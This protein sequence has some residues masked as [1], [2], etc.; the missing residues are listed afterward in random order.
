MAERAGDLL[1]SV[2]WL[3]QAKDRSVDQC[4]D[5]WDVRQRC[6]SKPRCGFVANRSV[7]QRRGREHGERDWRRRCRLA[8][9]N[10]LA[11]EPFDVVPCVELVTDAAEHAD[12]FE[13]HT[14]VK[15]L[16]RYVRQRDP[17]IRVL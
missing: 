5:R 15:A 1:A 7:E 10:E 2:Q 13:P 14:P 11:L 9:R 6:P 4:A 17:G 16:A 3:T 8:F 12:R